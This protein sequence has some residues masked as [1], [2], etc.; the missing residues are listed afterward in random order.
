MKKRILSLLLVCVMLVSLLPMSV[1]AADSVAQIVDGESYTKLSD[2][3]SAAPDG[4]TVKLLSDVT[5]S[6]CSLNGYPNEKAV[7]LDLN[8]FTFTSSSGDALQVFTGNT[9]TLKDSVGTGK[10]VAHAGSGIL[11]VKGTAYIKGGTYVANEDGGFA[12]AQNATAPTGL[13]ITGGTFNVNPSNFTYDWGTNYI[14]CVAEGYKAVANGTNPETWTVVSRYVAQIEGGQKY[15]TLQAAINAA[16]D[17]DV[18]EIIGTLNETNVSID[19]KIVFLKNLPDTVNVGAEC[20]VSSTNPS[21]TGVMY[22]DLEKAVKYVDSHRNTGFTH[23][24]SE[25]W[26]NNIFFFIKKDIKLTENI[27]LPPHG[28]TNS[29][30]FYDIEH[31]ATQFNLDLNGYEI[32]QKRGGVGG[33]WWSS[34]DVFDGAELTIDDTSEAKTGKISG[35]ASCIVM[36]N[37][38]KVILNG[39]TLSEIGDAD[40]DGNG[41]VKVRGSSRFVMN[42]GTVDGSAATSLLRAAFEYTNAG[43]IP[44][45][46]IKGGR[47]NALPESNRSSNSSGYKSADGFVWHSSDDTLDF[48]VTGGTFDFN[49]SAYVATGY[50]VT[51]N[52]NGTWTVVPTPVAQIGTTEHATLAEAIAAVPA[53]GTETTITMIGDETLAD[54]ANMTIAAGQNIVLDLNGKTVTGKNLNVSTWAFLT[55]NGTLEITDSSADKLGK[56]TSSTTPETNGFDGHY[57]VLNKN[58]MTLTAGTIEETSEKIGGGN[59]LKWALRNEASANQTVSLTING[60]AVIGEYNAVSNYVYDNTSTCSFTVNDGLIKTT[61][62]FSPV[63]MQIAKATAPNANITISGGEFIV[64]NIRNTNPNGNAIVYCDNEGS[65]VTDCS[66]LKFDVKNGKFNTFNTAMLVQFD[67]FN[68]NVKTPTSYITGGLFKVAP[69]ATEIAPGYA[70]VD[71]TDYSTKTAYPYVVKP[72]QVEMPKDVTVDDDKVK[73]GGEEIDLTLTKGEGA[74]DEPTA[75]QAKI[76][77]EAVLTNE[78]VSTFADTNIDKATPATEKAQVT[79]GTDTFDLSKVLNALK[80]EAETNHTSLTTTVTQSDKLTVDSSDFTDTD[81]SKAISIDL[82]AAAVTTTVDDQS[83]TVVSLSTTTFDVKP[84]ATIV[85][86]TATGTETIKAVI[87]NEAITA[88]IT[89]RLPVP[90]SWNGDVKVYHE[91]NLYGTYPVCGAEGKRYV[92]LASKEFSE[93]TIEQAESSSY[94]AVCKT[95][96]K[97]YD[98]LE[99]AFAN[100]A[101]GDTITLL[102]TCML[103]SLV[104]PLLM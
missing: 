7:T 79:V 87:P 51:D 94:G 99:E 47:V 65:S 44:S 100:V 11:C 52:N 66:N 48:T 35:I 23:P 75:D 42:G 40:Y 63:T 56:I 3:L 91:Q 69:A 53:D 22:G 24:E 10:V 101:E 83:Q 29:V 5:E 27:V 49:P 17:G 71:N 14:D 74:D 8:G 67:C 4:S 102:D 104:I 25:D 81:V 36:D 33:Y 86:T 88:P 46:Q 13:T 80:T 78:N 70:C 95:S 37:G 28:N 39:G 6:G 97:Y 82:T 15:E 62:R 26:E 72:V 89:F 68:P 20:E 45:I 19:N 84:V 21:S 32:S 73:V 30:L 98:N 12:C 76:A 64:Q 34:I 9:L 2:A 58:I 59:N 77:I 54:N 93:W 60:G 90:D 50:T 85:V 103:T 55:N 96:T 41:I 31:G 1:F 18:I 43:D 92:E 38:G 16:S 57:T 61:G